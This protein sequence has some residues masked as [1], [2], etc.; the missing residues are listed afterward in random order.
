MNLGS[1]NVV[2]RPRNT[3]ESVDLSFPFLLQVGGRRYLRLVLIVLVPLVAT[4]LAIKY[5]ASLSWGELWWVALPLGV[6]AQGPFTLAAGELMFTDEL[7]PWR[8]VKTFVRRIP[9]YTSALLL[10]RTLM[11]IAALTLVFFPLAWARFAFAPEASLLETLPA[12]RVAG[13]ASRLGSGQGGASFELLLWSALTLGF[14]F[15]AAEGLG[16]AIVSYTLQLASPWGDLTQEGGSLYAT[17]GW[18]AAVPLLSTMRFLRYVDRRTRSDGWDVQIRF[19]HVV[20]MAEEN[21]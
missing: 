16:H 12:S 17:L 13:R 15:V 20:Q 5:W 18:F 3:R 6:W 21:P 10:T 14:G 11:L 4:C 1:A 7:D 2:I 19:Q 8:V 9:S